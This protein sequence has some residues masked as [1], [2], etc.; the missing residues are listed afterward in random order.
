MKKFINL[1][2]ED[3]GVITKGF[4]RVPLKKKREEGKTR[5]LVPCINGKHFG[6]LEAPMGIRKNQLAQRVFK[7]IPQ[8][9]GRNW[10]GI[11]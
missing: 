7:E 11:G 5:R 10:G 1:G 2:L 4:L 8:K 6:K 9:G 3:M